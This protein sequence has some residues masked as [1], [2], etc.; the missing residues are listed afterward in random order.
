MTA[1]HLF[2]LL[3]VV[4]N[5]VYGIMVYLTNP[6]RSANQQFL[7]L[8][9]VLGAWMACVWNALNARTPEVATIG[10]RWASAFAQLV[11]TAFFL[12]RIAIIRPDLSWSGGV[13]R[14]LPLLLVNAAIGVMCLTPFYLHTMVMPDAATGADD[15]A[16]P[17]YG[18][19]IAIFIF[20]YL[21]A[22]GWLITLYIRDARQARGIQRTEIQYVLLACGAC[23]FTGTT[24]ALVI[25]VL[26]GS[27]RTA[28]M[29]PLCAV[30]LNAILAYGI[31][32]QR[33]MGVALVLRRATAYALLAVYLSLLYAAVAWFATRVL[34]LAGGTPDFWPGLLAAL[35]VAF[36]V[37][38]ANGRMQ[39]IANRLFINAPTLDGGLMVGQI[40]QALQSLSTTD[41]MARHFANIVSQNLDTDRVLILVGDDADF[42]EVHPATESTLRIGAASPLA[43]MLAAEALP[44]VADTLGRRQLLPGQADALDQMRSLSA[45]AAVG[46]RLKN[47]LSGFV[48]LGPR[49]SGRIYGAP[50]TDALRFVCGELAVAMENSRLFTETRNSR[51]YND[52]LLDNLGTGVIAMDRQQIITVINRDAQRIL[53][54]QPH[55]LIGKPCDTL[56]S[57]LG[58]ILKDTLDTGV[59][60]ADEEVR[61]DVGAKDPIFVRVGGSVFHSHTGEPLGALIV[62]HDVTRLKHLQTQIRRSDRLASMGT[63]SAGMAHEIKNPLVTIKTFTQLLPDRYDD[64]EFRDSFL[65]LMTEEVR[66]IDTLVNQLL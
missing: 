11:P 36:S 10:V 30:V 18:P 8:T 61:L 33:I 24:L 51:I 15:V 19:G 56:P 7:T 26:T 41:D 35:T 45:A 46:I 58:P 57:P 14:A 13:R 28:P 63:L 9:L 40:T 27:Y 1:A 66:R 48:L 31:A 23:L 4:V 60:H 53:G 6:R 38:P 37:V 59:R 21:T 47:R 44:L 54:R 12:L 20:Y 3:S 34:Q 2:V 42:V 39:R 16:Q 62:F 50:E 29:A 64:P 25:P 43:L 65:S 17:K 49:L 55:N 32:T 52:I 22:L 5:L